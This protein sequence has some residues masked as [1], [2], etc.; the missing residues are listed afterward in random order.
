M[1]RVDQSLPAVRRIVYVPPS[2]R[3][4]NGTIA[5]VE[6]TSSNGVTDPKRNESR[7]CDSN[8]ETEANLK[9][10]DSPLNMISTRFE[11]VDIEVYEAAK[12]VPKQD[13]K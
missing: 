13:E 11:G 9:A 10:L 6:S 4:T 8:P 5:S 12:V 7:S 1:G 2:S 3:S